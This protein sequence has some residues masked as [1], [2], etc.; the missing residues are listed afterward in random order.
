MASDADLREPEKI[1]DAVGRRLDF[2]QP[3]AIV[4]LGI[5]NFIPDDGDA[6]ALVDRPLAAVPAGS[7]LAISHPTT[8]INGRS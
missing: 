5:L 3:V 4:L 8:E 2:D 6:V 7:F 1:L